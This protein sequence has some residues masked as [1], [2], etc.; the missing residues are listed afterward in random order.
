VA[1][2]S[3]DEAVAAEA[4]AQDSQAAAAEAEASLTPEQ[5]ENLEQYLAY[6][7][8]QAEAEVAYTTAHDVTTDYFNQHPELLQEGETPEDVFTHA[9]NVAMYLASQ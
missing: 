4:K 8:A 7:A 3:Q 1:A 5:Q 2:T 6:E 9:Y